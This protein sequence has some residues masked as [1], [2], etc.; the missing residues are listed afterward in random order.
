M[1]LL[2]ATTQ[3][4]VYAKRAKKRH[5][6][7]GKHGNSYYYNNHNIQSGYADDMLDGYDKIK[8]ADGNKVNH[9]LN[10][11]SKPGTH[12]LKQGVLVADLGTGHYVY[13]NPLRSFSGKYALDN[14]TGNAN[15]SK[16]NIIIGTK[17]INGKPYLISLEWFDE[18][19][20]DNDETAHK[21]GSGYNRMILRPVTN[22]GVNYDHMQEYELKNGVKPVTAYNYDRGF[23]GRTLKEP[24]AITV[25]GESENTGKDQVI[26]HKGTVLLADKP[27]LGVDGNYY[28]E[29]VDYDGK[30][31]SFDFLDLVIKESDMKNLTLRKAIKSLL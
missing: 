11:A 3:T 4:V 28:R 31:D 5:I 27:F 22:L 17:N 6:S 2:N 29:I 13:D 8:A 24:D 18:D 1:P 16:T 26:T 9:I 30:Y 12:W 14:S 19:F 10:L 23:G 21:A 25:A 15:G 20:K 7:N